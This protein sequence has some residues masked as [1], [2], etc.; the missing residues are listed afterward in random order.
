[1]KNFLEITTGR[2][3]SKGNKKVICFEEK[4]FGSIEELA[5]TI[6]EYR[7]D[8]W[9]SGRIRISS[10]KETITQSQWEKLEKLVKQLA[11]DS[12]ESVYD[13]YNAYA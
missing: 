11:E 4:E 9:R 1:M 8:D 3:G 10:T 13:D 7:L 2:S 12:I 6:A 5:E